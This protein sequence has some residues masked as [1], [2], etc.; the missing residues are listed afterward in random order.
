M[1]ISNNYVTNNLAFGKHLWLT[2]DS[3]NIYF[4]FIHNHLLGNA[5]EDIVNGVLNNLLMYPLHRLEA[6]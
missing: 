4:R 2:L 1:A 3:S 6:S 5:V